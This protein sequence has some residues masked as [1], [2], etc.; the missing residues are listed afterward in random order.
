MRFGIGGFQV[1]LEVRATH[2]VDADATI[3]ISAAQLEVTSTA[4]M[5]AV[6]LVANVVFILCR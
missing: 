1:E 5:D 2:G 3:R 6:N 4:S